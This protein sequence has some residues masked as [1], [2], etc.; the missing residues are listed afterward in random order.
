MIRRPPRSTLFPYTTLFRSPALVLC[1]PDP[2]HYDERFAQLLAA[3]ARVSPVVEPAELGMAYVGTDG[4]EGLY[5]A[6]GAI[7]EAI[8]RGTRKWE[9][10]TGERT[11]HPCS[12]FRAPRSAVRVGVGQ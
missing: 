3:L 12:A 9:R 10:G 1:E 11:P 6:P 7:V 8:K 5:G 2:V 4:L